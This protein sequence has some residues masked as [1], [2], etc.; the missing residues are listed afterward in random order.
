[1]LRIQI[2]MDG[3]G[4]AYDNIFIE[5]LWRTLKYEEVYIHSYETVGEAKESLDRY[6]KFYNT[7][8]ASSIS[9]V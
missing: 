5:R 9:W 1:M 2:S 4:R 3:R 8:A 7:R 6:L